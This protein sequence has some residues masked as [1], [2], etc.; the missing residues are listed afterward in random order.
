MLDEDLV[1]ARTALGEAEAHSHSLGVSQKL[2][3][4]L[5][6]VDG[7]RSVGQLAPLM[8]AGEADEILEEL[9]EQGFIAPLAPGA[10]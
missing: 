2:R 4:A 7:R 5:S 8:R 9:Q 6:L 1:F 10:G 3:R